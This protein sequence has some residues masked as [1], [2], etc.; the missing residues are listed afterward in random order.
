MRKQLN[1]KD[2]TRTK[3]IVTNPRGAN[4]ENVGSFGYIVTIILS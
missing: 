4:V 2:V 3:W 1:P